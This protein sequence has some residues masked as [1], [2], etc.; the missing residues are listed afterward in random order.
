MN[1][2]RRVLPQ[3]LITELDD[4]GLP[5]S[6]VHGSKHLKIYIGG[7]LVGVYP[8]SHVGDHSRW[9]RMRNVIRKFGKGPA[10]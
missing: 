10:Q 5:W 4:L 3:K 2:S 7:W 8:R 1:A 9:L 6:A